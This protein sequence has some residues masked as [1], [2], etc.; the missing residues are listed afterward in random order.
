MSQNNNELKF[1]EQLA[2]S[3]NCSVNTLIELSKDS[4][5][6]IRRAVASNPNT[7]ERVLEELSEEFPE[8]VTANP[9]FDLLLLENPDSMF[10][11]LSL[12]RSLNT[13]RDKL[14]RLI[15]DENKD[16]R[17]AAIANSNIDSEIL[18]KLIERFKDSWQS[19]YINLAIAKN[20]NASS[21]ILDKLLDRYT[22]HDDEIRS[23]IVRH[24]NASSEILDKISRETTN[25]YCPNIHAPIARHPNTQASTLETLPYGEKSIRKDALKHPNISAYA[26]A[27][28]KFLEREIEPN[29]TLLQ[30]LANHPYYQVRKLVAESSNVTTAILNQLATDNRSSVQEAVCNNRKAPPETLD[31]VLEHTSSNYDNEIH[32]KIV[33]HPNTCASTLEKLAIDADQNL[34]LEVLKHP[35]ASEDAISIVRF[36]EGKLTPN[37][38]FWQKLLD[39][40]NDFIRLLIAKNP[41]APVDILEQSLINSNYNNYDVRLAVSGNPN[42]SPE[43]IERVLER[44]LKDFDYAK[45]RDK[46]YLEIIRHPHTSV[47]SLEKLAIYGTKDI[48]YKLLKHPSASDY[49]KYIVL[50]AHKSFLSPPNPNLFSKFA[51]VGNWKI[52]LQVAQDWNTPPAIL[53]KLTKDENKKVRQAAASNPK[54]TQKLIAKLAKDDDE[55]V[56]SGIASNHNI[57]SSILLE[58]AVDRIWRVRLGVA[59][60]KR[61]S[62]EILD[63]LITDRSKHVRHAALRQQTK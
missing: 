39:N 4:N 34:R 16:I 12:A 22:I 28:I 53:N 47:S 27:I 23:Q 50:Y 31:L 37:R 14:V 46:I 57:P 3:E 8:Q 59:Q 13:S 44:T 43:I 26:I 11:K 6:T 60:N 25:S 30:K 35:H 15:D 1:K 45:N 29:P 36:T 19:N 18:E 17:N 9:V 58:L 48:R 61:V 54:I 63:K 38:T 62:A 32:H 56:R 10:I 40:S 33:R 24:K 52:R 21:E 49:L 55:Y 42:S 2:L 51:T 5:V 7:P 41:D 20:P